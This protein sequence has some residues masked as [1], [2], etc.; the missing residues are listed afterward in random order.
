M[1]IEYYTH[2]YF[3]YTELGNNQHGRID[4]KADIAR[5]EGVRGQLRW[6]NIRCH[7]A[8]CVP[9]RGRQRA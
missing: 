9:D 5:Y 6:Q 4:R 3:I 2:A 1:T 8:V 7:P